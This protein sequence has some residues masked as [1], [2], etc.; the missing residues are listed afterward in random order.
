MNISWYTL[1]VNFQYL[2]ADFKTNLSYIILT[3]AEMRTCKAMFT[4]IDLSH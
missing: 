1:N 4:H 2:T 3:E